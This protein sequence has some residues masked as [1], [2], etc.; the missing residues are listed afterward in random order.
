[1]KLFFI[2]IFYLVFCAFCAQ[3]QDISDKNQ[4]ILTHTVFGWHPYWANGKE[5][6]YDWNLISD[7][8]YF[9]YEVDPLSGSPITTHQFLTA[10]SVT[11]ALDKG[12]KVHLSVTLFKDHGIF[13]TNENSKLNLI[14]NLGNLLQ[15]RGAHGINIDF[16]NLPKS[17]LKIFNQFVAQL[18]DSLH[19]RNAAYELS[20]C[21]FAVD[22]NNSFQEEDLDKKVDFFTLMAYDF[23]YGGS[24]NAGP[25]D[26]L[27]P[28]KNGYDYSISRSVTYYT[29]AG[30][31]PSKLILGL[32]YY[33]REWQTIS[34][35]PFAR[36]TGKATSSRT[37]S[38]IYNQLNAQEILPKIEEKSA[39]SYF[40]YQKEGNWYQCWYSSD[41]QL[42]QRYQLVKRRDLKG[43]GIW[44]LGNDGIY[45]NYWNAIKDELT[46]EH[47]W[48]NSDTI[49]DE[50]GKFG[51]YYN[52]E[53]LNYTIAPKNADAIKVHFLEFDLEDG[54]DSLWLY[55][56]I[57]IDAKLIGAYSG[58]KLPQDVIAKSGIL[59]VQFK[60][61]GT[62]RSKGWAF[63]YEIK[64][65]KGLKNLKKQRHKRHAFALSKIFENSS[66]DEKQKLT[67]FTPQGYWDL[68][69][70]VLE[71]KDDT[72]TLAKALVKTQLISGSN[73]DFSWTYNVTKKT[74]NS[75]FGY[76]FMCDIAENNRIN[77]G[78]YIK[79][80]PT[81][82]ALQLYKIENGYFTLVGEFNSI[83]NNTFQ[84]TIKAR[85][86]TSMGK[87]VIEMDDKM[88]GAWKDEKPLL[89]SNGLAFQTNK[90][91]LSIQEVSVID[92]FA[93]TAL[94]LKRM[95]IQTMAGK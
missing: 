5:K 53:S 65:R 85:Y 74:E 28:Y 87:I 44:T 12:K 15:Q 23:H 54:F 26:P 39:S 18:G 33:G 1:M 31:P 43:I 81:D 79:C 37:V 58:N 70:N 75:R 2:L 93:N 14:N 48:K 59:N 25:V 35:D 50:G 76:Y 22:W 84:H 94:F 46:T 61:D 89:F 83:L 77:N 68:A 64:E 45:Q 36:T 80:I 52:N 78:Y 73:I 3:G 11:T 69:N 60:S 47:D 91:A 21:V 8:C 34:N 88:V 7:F 32:P 71:Q 30:I 62:N 92:E 57:A 4:P 86:L 55:D 17:Q 13:L 16:E 41:E 19:A 67:W 9:S 90:T 42:K 82:N 6:N 56:G 95:D 72:I 38:Q 51:N 24:E 40:S 63:V 49:Y 27:Y 20:L 10:P 29:A 66:L